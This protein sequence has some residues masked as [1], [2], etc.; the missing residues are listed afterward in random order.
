MTTLTWEEETKAFVLRTFNGELAQQTREDGWGR[1]RGGVHVPGE[2]VL[3]TR[4][5]Y[6]ALSMY[7]FTK[8]DGEARNRLTGLHTAYRSSLALETDFRADVPANLP[9]DVMPFQN[10]GVEYAIDKPHALIGDDMGVGKTAQAIMVANSLNAGKMLVACPANARSQWAENIKVWSTVANVYR[11]IHVIYRSSDGVDPFA[12]WTILSYALLRN[13][14]I[15]AALLKMGFDLFIP[16]EAHALKTIISQQS[17]AAFGSLDGKV[18]G[19]GSVSSKILPMTGTPLP[20]RPRECY[21]M[22]RHLCWD[23][24]D[25]LSED[26]F[27]RR[28]N[29]SSTMMTGHIVE[30]NTRLPELRARMRCNW[31]VR[32]KKR[33]VLPQLPPEMHEL[34]H[35]EHDGAIRQVLKTESLL[36]ID[37]D[38]VLPT[39]FQT[40]GHIAVVRHQMGVAKIPR[41]LEHIKTVMEGGAGKLMVVAYHRKVMET[42]YEKLSDFNPAIIIGGQTPRRRDKEKLKFINDPTCEIIICQINAAGE[43]MDGLQGVCSL[44][45]FVEASWTPKD[46]EQVTGRLIRWGQRFGVL[47]QYLISPDSLDEKILGKSIKKGQVVSITLDG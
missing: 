4:E 7:P 3:F 24:I 44:G 20:N 6:A 14:V 5:P 27:I 43:A 30:Y 8:G 35:I 18:A 41:C 39:D 37:V 25:W 36:N 10:A 28:Y 33:A 1:S 19:I 31:M 9:F 32:R 38:D 15:Y 16:D 29:P 45:V 12:S 2:K 11:K 42:L 40:K 47:W 23:S 26:D 46:N 34:V 22:A 13:P 21:N 17:V